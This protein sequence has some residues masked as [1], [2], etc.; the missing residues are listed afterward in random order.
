MDRGGGFSVAFLQP[1]SIDGGMDPFLQIDAFAL[2]QPFFAPHP[3]A[4]FSAV[5][6][7]FPES[8]IG[9]FNRDSLGSSQRIAPGG[10]HWTA[11]GRGVLHEEVPEIRGV[12]VLGLQMFINLPRAAQQM[13][14]TMI[15]LEPQEVPQYEAPGVVARVV[16]GS[17][18]GVDAAAQTPTPGAR[19]VDL[20]LAPGACFS[21]ELDDRE[22]C[23][24]WIFAGSAA[25][26]SPA[27]VQ[28]LSTFDLVGYEQGGRKITLQAGDHG[29][30]IAIC[31]GPPLDQPVVASGPIVM[32]TQADIQ[33]AV[34]AYRSGAMGQLSQT[35]YGAEGRPLPI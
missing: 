29:A 23:F 25:A 18:N 6:Y 16:F 17:S 19:L 20:T 22:N 14:P 21:Q 34:A 24:A 15:H 10:M 30:R 2:S 35:L 33:N 9:F 11:A 8:P 26:E 28:S 31:G 4:G 12:A 27:G 13:P 5:T 1:E 32:S 3:H 7:I